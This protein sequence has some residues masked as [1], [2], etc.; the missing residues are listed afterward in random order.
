MGPGPSLV[1]IFQPDG[2]LWREL[3]GVLPGRFPHGVTVASSDFNGDNYDDIA[4][5][6]GKGRDPLVV[7][8]DGFSLGDPTGSKQVTHLLVRRPGRQGSGREPRGRL[9]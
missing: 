3:D 6:A 1:R 7:G 2:T 8:I 4:I 9:L 5:G